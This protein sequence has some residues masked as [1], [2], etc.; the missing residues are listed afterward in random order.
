MNILFP[1]NQ[2]YSFVFLF[3]VGCVLGIV[4]DVFKVKR[5]LLGCNYL[6]LFFD[7]LIFSFISTGTLIVC[8]Y[9]TSNGVFRWFVFLSAVLGFFIYNFTVSHIVIFVFGYAVMLIHKIVKTVLYPF[10]VLLFLMQKPLT[11][12]VYAFRRYYIKK[13][14]LRYIY[15]GSE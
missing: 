2:I 10:V 15:K 1:P 13:R 4:Y 12:I 11:P 3:I 5:M 7:D 14:I 6:V 8:I 9:F